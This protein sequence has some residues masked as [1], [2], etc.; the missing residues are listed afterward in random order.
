M[1]SLGLLKEDLLQIY[2]DPA[3]DLLL[4]EPNLSSVQLCCTLGEAV[5]PPMPLSTL[6]AIVCLQLVF[7]RCCCGSFKRVQGS[8][9]L[10]I[11]SAE[12][13]GVFEALGKEREECQG[14]SFDGQ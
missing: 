1:S 7:N 14:I 3:W 11:C 8:Y 2:F 4:L 12:F 6:C 9:L 5:T 10:H 13:A